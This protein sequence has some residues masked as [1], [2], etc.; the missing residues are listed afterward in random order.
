MAVRMIRGDRGVGDIPAYS[1]FRVL[2][3]FLP[4]LLYADTSDCF[5]PLS[6]ILSRGLLYFYDLILLMRSHLATSRPVRY[7]S[8]VAI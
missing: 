1:V 8:S 2:R 6:P 5:F 7:T 4:A 3:F